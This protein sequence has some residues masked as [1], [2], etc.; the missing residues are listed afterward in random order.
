M[1]NA[2][3]SFLSDSYLPSKYYYMENNSGQ[4]DKILVLMATYNGARYLREQIDSILHQEGVDVSILI[5][6][7]GSKDQTPAIL[8]EY[9]EKYDNI[10]LIL[11]DNIGCKK[12]FARLASHALQHFPEFEYFAFADQDDVWLKNKLSTGIVSLRKADPSLPNLYCCR[13]QLTDENLNPLAINR[14]PYLNTFGEALM[15]QPYAGCTMIFNRRA[16]Q[17]FTLGNPDKMF[18]HDEWLYKMCIACGG[19]VTGDP[20]RYILYRQHGKNAVG[21]NQGV[22]KSWKRRLNMFISSDFQRSRE[23]ADILATYSGWISPRRLEALKT[24]AGYKK[25]LKRKSTL[26]RSSEFKTN[27]PV[28]NTIFKLA[29]LFNRF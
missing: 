26:L 10:H 14:P 29:V 9:A 25:S 22:L 24:V 1:E 28:F 27:R 23:A 15:F 11:E 2:L 19:D 8:K 7:D 6:D 18:L 12:C 5:R 13:T 16:L 17:L 4:Y 21:G 3:N 20:E